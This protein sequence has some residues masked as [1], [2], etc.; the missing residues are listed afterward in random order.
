MS[1]T[2]DPVPE[3]GMLEEAARWFVLLAS[4]EANET[5]HARWLAWRAADARHEAAW[6]RTQTISSKFSGIPHGQ[7][8]AAAEVLRTPA[9]VAPGRRK[10][11]GQLA[12][13]CV[14]GATGWHGWRRSD[15]SADRVTAIG[16]Q[17]N[18]TLADGSQLWMDTDTA[19]DIAF[20]ASARLIRL[21]RGR[22]LIATASRTAAPSLMVETAEGR[23]RALGT[24]F[25]VRQEAGATLVAVLEARVAIHA[26]EATGSE[27]IVHAGQSARFDR[28]GILGWQDVQL[29]DAAWAEGVLIADDM[30]LADF[31]AELARYRATP[32]LCDP[33]VRALRISGT[34]PLNDTDRA[35]AALPRTLSVHVSAIR[36]G[37]PAS[38]VI[39][40]LK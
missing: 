25:A 5:D 1:E 15:W 22:I 30:P 37:D 38:G 39:L 27:P 17:R 11:L 34:Y 8:R 21:R 2:A 23:V 19:L 16:E 33:A 3:S 12:L 40:R 4:G 13:L 26:A 36:S 29:S 24:R 35:L 32:L 10:F 18:L 31:V 6:L 9:P 7:A 14:V 20:D 28:S